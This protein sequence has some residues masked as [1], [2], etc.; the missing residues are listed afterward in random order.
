M[1]HKIYIKNNYLYIVDTLDNN[2][3]YE[4]LAKEVRFR[5]NY[6]NSTDFYVDNVHGFDRNKKIPFNEIKD[7]NG[8]DYPDVNTF[9]D[10]YELN[11]GNHNGGGNGK[12]VASISGFGVDNTDDKNPVIQDIHG[13]QIT[14][15]TNAI[16]TKAD[17][18]DI[19]Q[20]NQ[21][22]SGGASWE[23]GLMFNVTDLVYVIEGNQYNSTSVQVTLSD[24]DPT[25]NRID[26][27]VA[28]TS[29]VVSVIEG[30]P[31]MSPI[32][33]DIDEST[34]IEVTFVTIEAGATTP[35][36]TV[37]NVYI[38]N[39]GDP[40]EWQATTNNASI[41]T[42]A[43]SN[44]SSG[45][46]HIKGTASATNHRINLI[47]DSSYTVNNNSILEF[48]VYL[49]TAITNDER[50]R[51]RF[52]SNG[53]AIGIN[54]EV[55]NGRFG[56]SAS[57]V[58]VYQ[59]IAIPFSFFQVGGTV[60][61][62]RL[63]CRN[64]VSTI[65]FD[66]DNI[67]IQEGFGINVISENVQSDMAETN[68][69]FDSFV[70][71]KLAQF[72]G[73]NTLGTRFNSTQLQDFVSELNGL[74]PKFVNASNTVLTNLTFMIQT[75]T[76]PGG[77]NEYFVDLSSIGFST[78]LFKTAFALQDNAGTTSA[79]IISGTNLASDNNSLDIILMES[80]TSGVFLGGSVEGLEGDTDAGIEVCVL[81]I[82]LT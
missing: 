66:I 81:V 77:A 59:K 27:I 18:S 13:P 12:G 67:R 72:I 17:Y 29:G 57:K 60:D 25:N 37:E 68:N 74:I 51:F 41:V 2:R 28:N 5:K 7:E 23:S 14:E 1:A 30:V 42:N 71:N 19:F 55:R 54:V 33:P 49:P 44:P 35:E 79:P 58:G 38:D 40:S 46:T 50:F 43:T 10:F 4:G 32:K 31:S 69:A 34:Q 61:E 70:K 63:I 80:N 45:T 73:M 52:R 76:V 9:V 3:V 56:F 78:V 75:Y 47:P 39:V 20:G 48:S 16:S 15:N 36:I 82:G 21:L 22:L 26:V 6:E 64:I 11:T 53:V 24:S 62:L 8:D 65:D